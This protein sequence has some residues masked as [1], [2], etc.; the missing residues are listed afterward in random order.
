MFE[1]PKNYNQM[2]SRLNWTTAFAT[3]IYTAALT[4]FG[5][6][7]YVPIAK[8]LIPPVEV[9]GNKELLSWAA[10]AFGTLPLLAAI[11]AFLLSRAFELHNLASKALQLRFAW[12]KYYIVKPL[13][14]RA[15]SNLPLGREAVR[16]VMNEFYYEAV[17][18]I[19]PHYVELFW[20]Y[21]LVFWVIFEH[22]LVVAAS[23]A[24]LTLFQVPNLWEPASY[25]LFLLV[26]AALH[27]QLITTKKTRDQVRQIPT[28]DVE[29]YFRGLQLIAKP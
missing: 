1:Q 28:A 24:V 23:I 27:F 6:L 8:G 15:H 5:F 10:A 26:V 3:F 25:L 20:R 12:D 17:K 7:P 29:N 4:K 14:D 11:G 16:K 2:L 18:K 19:D 22:I 21:A 9:E 13:R